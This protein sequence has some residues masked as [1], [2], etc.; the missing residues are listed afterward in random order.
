MLELD[1]VVGGPVD[2]RLN[3]KLFAHGEV[4]TVSENFGVRLTEILGD[5]E[6]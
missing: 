3:G 5:R 1:K 4:V 2:I 6:E